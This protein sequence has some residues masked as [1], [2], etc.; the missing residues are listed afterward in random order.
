MQFRAKCAGETNHSAYL[1]YYRHVVW[2]CHRAV[3][4]SGGRVDQFLAKSKLCIQA[5]A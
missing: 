1:P 2:D 3:E 4:L 5:N